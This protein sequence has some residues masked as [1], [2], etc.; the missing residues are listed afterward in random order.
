MPLIK[1]CKGHQG[2]VASASTCS[3]NLPLFHVG[4]PYT[5][6][7]ICQCELFAPAVPLYRREVARPDFSSRDGLRQALLHETM[8]SLGPSA[9]SA[10]SLAPDLVRAVYARGAYARL[11]A[12]IGRLRLRGIRTAIAAAMD[13]YESKR[14][15]EAHDV[16]MRIA[17]KLAEEQEL[18]EKEIQ[19]EDAAVEVVDCAATS[20]GKE[21]IKASGDSP[22]SVTGKKRPR[23]ANQAKARNVQGS[24]NA[25]PSPSNISPDVERECSTNASVIPA[26]DHFATQR[27]SKRQK[28]RSRR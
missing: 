2:I 12:S 4:C 15:K 27:P 18:K 20:S 11:P 13:S 28:V 8:T 7:P 1:D 10:Q 3:M 21:K 19:I 25:P 9:G 24:S 17:L 23:N 6:L 16:Q 22:D 26:S 5:S 14:E